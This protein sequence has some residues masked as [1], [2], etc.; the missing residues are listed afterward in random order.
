MEQHL[1]TKQVCLLLG[2]SLSTFYRYCKAGLL[3][4][5]FLTFGKHR[6][7]SLSQLRQSFNLDSN[8]VITVCYSR[9]SSH[10]QKKDLISQEDK[11]LNYAKSNNYQNIISITDL[12]SGLNYKKPGLKKL[13]SLIFSGQVKTLIINHKDRLLRFGSEL[14]FYLCDLFKVQVVIIE[15]KA[16][17]SFEETLSA[18]V[19]ELMTVFCAKL[20]GKRSHKNKV[21]LN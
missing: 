4:P 20:Y 1:S 2:I 6:R 16:D 12:G 19:I 9:V 10:D 3:K 17:K 14:I 5:A 8:A 18:D 7:F 13:I 11:L 21:K 15:N